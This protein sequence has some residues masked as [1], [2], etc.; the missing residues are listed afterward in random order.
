V[1]REVRETGGEGRQPAPAFEAYAAVHATSVQLLHT[2]IP[3]FTAQCPASLLAV[4][5]TSS[6]VR[7]AP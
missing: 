5:M 1:A 7:H 4:V 2:E 6:R 3:I